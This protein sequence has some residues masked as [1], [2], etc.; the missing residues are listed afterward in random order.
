MEERKLTGSLITP[1]FSYGAYRDTPE[2]RTAQIKGML[3]YMYRIA[4]PSQAEILRRNE[5]ILFGEASDGAGHASPVR[6]GA[7][8]RGKAGTMRILL[9]DEKKDHNPEMRFL[10]QGTIQLSIK[11][12]PISKEV[13][14]A[15][16]RQP[17]IDWYVD[18][19]ILSLTLCGL[20]RRS[21]KGRG[22]IAIEK[23][24][25]MD[26]A[27][28]KEWILGTL[29]RTVG[30]LSGGTGD[31]FYVFSEGAIKPRGELSGIQRPVIQKIW[32]GK[33]LKQ[34][35]EVME[36]LKKIDKL[37]HY[38]KLEKD[39]TDEAKATGY[40]YKKDKLASPLWISLVKVKD[41]IYPVYM[42]VKAFEEFKET[43]REFD[44]ECVYRDAF[45]A[46]LENRRESEVD[47]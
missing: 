8:W 35:Q 32:F 44:K 31:N 25:M 41:G 4:C 15:A 5:G 24:K 19:A 9:H 12:R 26:L 45:A 21:R 38:D 11:L 27:Q 6:L 18:L 36:F 29:N 3:R 14:N 34:R 20:G 16:D 30:A 28:A 33:R 22:A 13:K 47:G 42:C 7:I 2:F 17:D 40:S 23:M 10:D 1:M 39:R 37:G 43:I 46:R